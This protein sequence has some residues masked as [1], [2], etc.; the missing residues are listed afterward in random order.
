[1][2][3]KRNPGAGPGFIEIGFPIRSVEVVVVT[4]VA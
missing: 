4:Y 2:T 3:P 1:V